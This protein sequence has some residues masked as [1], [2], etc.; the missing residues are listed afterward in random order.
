MSITAL[1]FFKRKAVAEVTTIFQ[2]EEI[3][4]RWLQ[5]RYTFRATSVNTQP[6]NITPYLHH[7]SIYPDSTNQLIAL[8][9][10]QRSNMGTAI[11]VYPLT[12][13]TSKISADDEEQ[14][15]LTPIIGDP[16]HHTSHIPQRRH[17]P[18]QLCRHLQPVPDT[19]K[20]PPAADQGQRD[21]SR[22]YDLANSLTSAPYKN[23]PISQ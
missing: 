14:Q 20:S 7:G 13:K 4:N 18:I 17:Q 3:R 16:D 9:L 10:E 2:L 21:I 11:V 19:P 23:P 12:T 8:Q 22:P 1:R 6:P 5:S 15:N